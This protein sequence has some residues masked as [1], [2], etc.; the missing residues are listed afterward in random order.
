MWSAL[1]GS[2]TKK[3]LLA[4]TI[5]AGMFRSAIGRSTNFFDPGVGAV[6]CDDAGIT[7]LS[8]VIEKEDPSVIFIHAPFDTDAANSTGFENPQNFAKTQERA[9]R[10]CITAD[11]SYTARWSTKPTLCKGDLAF[12]CSDPHITNELLEWA[13]EKDNGNP[14]CIEDL[15]D[16]KFADIIGGIAEAHHL[17]RCVDIA[18]VSTEEADAESLVP[19]DAIDDPKD[20]AAQEHEEALDEEQ[21]ML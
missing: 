13:K 7:R 17:D 3:C 16:T 19:I 12:Y 9:G 18:F 15:R 2:T 4:V 11:T 14:C 10:T 6:K 20:E 5:C 8:E 21:D 1:T